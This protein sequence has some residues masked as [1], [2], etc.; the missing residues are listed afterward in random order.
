VGAL[1]ATLSLGGV[2]LMLVG[3]VVE[4]VADASIRRRPRL[5]VL[6]VIFVLAGF[7]L[8]KELG[9]QPWQIAL[10][11]LTAVAILTYAGLAVW[12]V[13]RQPKSQKPPRDAHA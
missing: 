2:A 1:E 8:P 3:L 4:T 6:G 10:R 12:R 11:T 13:F 9:D 5:L 7:L